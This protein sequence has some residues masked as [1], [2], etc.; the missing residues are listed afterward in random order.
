[1][2]E[3]Y[4]NVIEWGPNIYGI[5]EASQFYFQ[6]Y[7][8]QLSLN[9]CLFLASI[10][11]RPKGFMWHFDSTGNLR[12]QGVVQQKYLTNLMLRR[13]VL[14]AEDTI[15]KSFPLQ[16]TGRARSFLRITETDSTVIDS[17]DLDEFDFGSLSPM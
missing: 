12:N 2:L 3:V 17:L 1:M 6:K 15:Y 8:S 13:G 5:G 10:V 14:T 11:P 16:V 9:E 7:P 4:F